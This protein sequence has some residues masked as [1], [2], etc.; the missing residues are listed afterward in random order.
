MILLTIALIIAILNTVLIILLYCKIKWN[1][2]PIKIELND[3]ELIL[4]HLKSTGYDFII[5]CKFTMWNGIR[6]IN[7]KG[8]IK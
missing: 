7:W 5:G 8:L 3:N 4:W 2:I 1:R 6:L